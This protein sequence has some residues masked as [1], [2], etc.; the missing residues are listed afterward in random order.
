MEKGVLRPCGKEAAGMDR[1]QKTHEPRKISLVHREAAGSLT[2]CGC[3][4][5][6]Q[7]CRGKREGSL[8]QTG[9]GI[10]VTAILDAVRSKSFKNISLSC[11]SAL[12]A[13]AQL[14]G[15]VTRPRAPSPSSS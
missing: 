2:I 15:R 13:W 3:P 10:Q 8:T 14:K 1:Y 6:Q 7:S 11:G 5:T 9:N 12:S 4:T